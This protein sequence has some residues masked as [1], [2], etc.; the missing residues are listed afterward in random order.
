[1]GT[2][3]KVTNPK[4]NGIFSVQAYHF[5]QENNLTMR[6]YSASSASKQVNSQHKKIE[7][8]KTDLYWRVKTSKNLTRYVKVPNLISKKER[9]Q[10]F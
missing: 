2:F 8:E 9:L 7:E 4:Q 1:M 3:S 5:I 6:K 10:L